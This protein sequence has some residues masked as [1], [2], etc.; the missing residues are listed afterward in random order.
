MALMKRA[1]AHL[2]C[3][4]YRRFEI[5]FLERAVD[6]RAIDKLRLSE[7]GL[8]EIAVF[9]SAVGTAQFGQFGLVGANVRHRFADVCARIQQIIVFDRVPNIL[10][11]HT[12][13][14]VRIVTPV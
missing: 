13:S 10:R 7:I 6:K 8:R 3:P 2:T 12:F 9:K 1:A 4:Q 5:A 11:Q 14:P